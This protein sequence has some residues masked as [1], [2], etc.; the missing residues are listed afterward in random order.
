MLHTLL[1]IL[2]ECH[3]CLSEQKEEKVNYTKQIRDIA[4]MSPS[5]LKNC[6]QLRKY[7]KRLFRPEAGDKSLNY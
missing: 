3:Y 4:R 5:Q 6:L 7:F 2:R 1:M